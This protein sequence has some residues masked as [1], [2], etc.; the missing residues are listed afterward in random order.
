MLRLDEPLFAWGPAVAEHPRDLSG[1]QIERGL[2][3]LGEAVAGAGLGGGQDFSR[4]G[5]ESRASW[6]RPPP[7]W[8]GLPRRQER[9]D[10]GAEVRE[11]EPGLHDGHDEHVEGARLPEPASSRIQR[12]MV[13]A[14]AIRIARATT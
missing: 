13:E 6:G 8:T 2:G 1:P 4:G 12:G 11:R 14:V 3:G 7:P 10:S 5:A 9:L